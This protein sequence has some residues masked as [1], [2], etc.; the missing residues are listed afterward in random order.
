MKEQA[1][2]YVEK[3]HLD[4]QSLPMGLCLYDTDWHQ[5]VIGIV[6]S[7]IKEIY[8]RPVIAFADSDN[9]EIKGSARSIPV[10]ISETR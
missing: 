8:H 6:A 10:Y 5:G 3:L 7:R 9:Q 4:K 2:Q 1:L